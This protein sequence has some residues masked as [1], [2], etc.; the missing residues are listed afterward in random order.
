ML[1]VIVQRGDGDVAGDDIVDALVVTTHVAI[2]RGTKEIDENQSFVDVQ[3]AAPHTP[4][5]RPG[6]LI[7]GIDSSTG[8]LWRGKVCSVEISMDGD[9]LIDTLSIRRPL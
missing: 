6:H 4:G 3:L 2:V 9:S 1:D 5:I 7:E 8:T